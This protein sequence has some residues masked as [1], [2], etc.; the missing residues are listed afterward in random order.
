V[1]GSHETFDDSEFL[2]EH[3]SNWCK[4]VGCA[5]GIGDDVLRSSVLI[6]VNTV[7]ICGGAILS[8]SREDNFL[9]TTSKM[10][11]SL[12]LG[13]ESTSRF[14]DNGS[15]MITPLN[16]GGVLLC[17]EMN[18]VAINLNGFVINL[19]WNTKEDINKCKLKITEINISY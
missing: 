19:V 10:G 7:D 4:A 18:G 13:Q 16:V 12:L 15:V 11:R 17:E 2:I 1:D 6:V 8:G 14:T 3:L 9:G 5:R